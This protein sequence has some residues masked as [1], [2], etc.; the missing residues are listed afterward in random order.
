MTF[1]TYVSRAARS[2]VFVV[3]LACGPVVLALGVPQLELTGRSANGPD[4]RLQV[5]DSLASGDGLRIRVTT[6]ERSYL[7]VVALGATGSAVLLHPFSR[8]PVDALMQRAS[9]RTIPADGA[10]LPLDRHVGNETVIAIASATPIVD[11]EDLLLEIE[12]DAARGGSIDPIRLREFG[13]AVSFEFAHRARAQVARESSQPK[14]FGNRPAENGVLSGSGSR[15][16][17]MLGGGTQTAPSSGSALNALQALRADAPTRPSTRRSVAPAVIRA[18]SRTTAA[19]RASNIPQALVSEPTSNTLPCSSCSSAV[20]SVTAP[21]RTQPPVFTSTVSTDAQPIGNFGAAP[22]STRVTSQPRFVE[23]TSRAGDAEALQSDTGQSIVATRQPTED[24]SVGWVTSLFGAPEPSAKPATAVSAPVQRVTSTLN[25]PSTFDIRPTDP[26]PNVAVSADRL[27]TP[28]AAT[29]DEVVVSTNDGDSVPSQF[30]WF[31]GLFDSSGSEEANTEAPAIQ[32]TSANID[33]DAPAQ[34]VVVAGLNVTPSSRPATPR[35]ISPVAQGSARARRVDSAVTAPVRQQ[36]DVAEVQQTNALAAPQPAPESSSL[37]GRIGNFFSTSEPDTEGVV[38]AD[39]SSSDS[40]VK[41]TSPEPVRV[42]ERVTSKALVA[43]T[44][45]TPPTQTRVPLEGQVSIPQLSRGAVNVPQTQF[46][47]ADES[48]SAAV[49]PTTGVLA[50]T[51]SRIA[52]LLGFA[53]S[54]TRQQDDAADV[55]AAQTSAASEALATSADTEVPAPALPLTIRSVGASAERATTEQAA[56]TETQTSRANQLEAVTAA[57]SARQVPKTS[58][59]V[60]PAPA[61]AID[62]TLAASL[63]AVQVVRVPQLGSAGPAALAAATSEVEAEAADGTSAL[64][65]TAAIP[66]QPVVSVESPPAALNPL[67][68]TP[69]QG[70]IEFDSTTD[71]SPTNAVMLVVTPNSLGSALLIDNEGHLL[72]PW[73]VVQ[74]FSTVTVWAKAA[75]QNIPDGVSPM[76]ARV[77]R[78]NRQSDLA[79]LVL[80]DGAVAAEPVVLADSVDLKRGEIVHL[81]G[82]S[83]GNR[84]THVMARFSRLKKRHSWVTKGRFVHRE[85]VLSNKAT[86]APEA[87]GGAVF[88]S[89]KQLIGLNIQVGRNSGQ[90]YSV[91]VETIRRFLAGEVASDPPPKA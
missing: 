21:P 45:S 69:S 67:G 5:G 31:G 4:R 40:P 12:A 24:S 70:R 48:T 49:T 72:T 61:P 22:A 82:H 3:S 81:I 44:P 35:V 63:P 38:T 2:G 56:A 75:G 8:D 33:A 46:A 36:V 6:R 37:F 62:P 23:S 66:A 18:D 58:Q 26:A 7:Y 32:V 77:V 15:I 53:S 64:A 13:Q 59:S 28:S 88:N 83:N 65:T 71:A 1:V 90:V 74:G 87:T 68:L 27:E 78:A 19:A 50:A 57:I 39:S 79:L 47:K 11:V 52:A 42:V 17:A 14:L 84:W 30:A 85:A 41:V 86:G 25:A 43:G 89:Q 9:S 80:E 34:A 54:S 29:G 10:V 20:V 76:V 60:A 73:H 91:T 51:G 16:S 55:A